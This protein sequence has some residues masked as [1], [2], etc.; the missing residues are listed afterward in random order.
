M[1]LALALGLAAPGGFALA[2]IVSYM[3]PALV[4]RRS[5]A[6]RRV[7]A[8]LAA[9][10]AFAASTRPSGVAVVDAL[11]APALA[12]GITLLAARARPWTVAGAAGAVAL[13]SVASPN[14]GLAFAAA[15]A[16][17]AMAL[18]VRSTPLVSAL[19]GAAVA[20]AALGL[21]LPGPSAV[22]VVMATALLAPMAYS[23]YRRLQGK[24]RKR[25]HAITFAAGA[26]VA[27][28]ALVGLVALAVAR[29]SLERAVDHAGKGLDAARA[30][31]QAEAARRL[32]AAG[33]GFAH[34]R[35]ALAAWWARPA[36]ALPVVGPHLRALRVVAETGTDLADAGR[37]VA[38]ATDLGGL[39]IEGGRV[40]L[41]A[42][43]AIQAPLRRASAE[44]TAAV[45]RLRN[46]RSPWLVPAVSDRL[47]AN[48]ARLG[49]ADRSLRASRD[50]VG[51]LPQLLGADGPRRWFLAIQTPSE[52]RGSGGFIGNYGEIVADQGTLDL[53]RFGRIG[54]LNTGGDPAKRV[55]TGPSDVLPRYQR[56][57]VATTWQ[58]VTLSPDFPSVAKVIA[59]LYPQS[60]GR[61]V[62][63][64]I[65]VD[66]KGVA[67]LLRLTG[68]LS[69]PP[70]PV[71]L[72]AKNAERIL[73]YD[74]YVQLPDTDRVDFL[75][76]ATRRL[77]EQLTTRQ[78]PPIPKVL[79]ALGPAVAK[80]HLMVST[81]D[82]TE[83][84]A[85]GRAGINGQLA[86]V[87]GGDA[88]A[89]VTQ[90][91]SGS[92]I[93]WFLKRSVEYRPTYDR[94]TGKLSAKLTITL[95]NAAPPA[96][97]PDYL[98]GNALQPPLPRGTNRLYLSVYTPL[99][100]AAARVDGAEV[101]MESEVEAGR[102]VYSAYV[103]IPPQGRKVL[104]LDLAGA[105]PR[106]TDYRLDLHAQPLVTPD[107]VSVRPRGR[108][109]RR[110]VLNG[111]ETLRFGRAAGKD[112]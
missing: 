69:V 108:A 96:G 28:V 99:G 80:K 87:R 88:L 77:W 50:V 61:P 58:N 53:V 95:D 57:D 56:F 105:L 6:L 12:A 104:Q 4:R 54:E 79:A 89:V 68:P 55:L 51:V 32:D 13:A 86:P 91:A 33:E 106:G 31:D 85:L 63:G 103:D 78:L 111:D 36:L 100:L 7:L 16:A 18:T 62:D 83:D 60:G 10:L 110:L 1:P 65:A 49:D 20:N 67:A 52:A 44:V 45:A 35:R 25:F 98:I 81:A 23:G 102:K 8:A 39:R 82:P 75:G 47:D 37:Q 21:R 74:Q 92:K 29:P 19:V 5:V 24:T 71:P 109:P 101:A 73:L 9:A 40:P 17:L 41:D 2:A 42:I 46:A 48:L 107:R 22:E 93:D 76:E 66:P 11:L 72:T 15:G 26:V 64:V 97:L 70:W 59:G 34:A 84:A 14:P 27:P 94:G 90:N 112:R 3:A 43:V 38:T 30:A